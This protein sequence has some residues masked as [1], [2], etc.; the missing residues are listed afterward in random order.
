MVQSSLKTGDLTDLVALLQ[1]ANL[2]GWEIRRVRETSDQLYLNF[3]QMESLRRV[4]AETYAVQIY[5]LL[6][7]DGKTWLGESGWTAN[8][9]DDF[10]ADLTKARERALLALNPIFH[11]P[12]PDQHYQPLSL[13]DDFIKAQPRQVLWH[14]RHD[15][16]QAMANVLDIELAAA[17][18]Y[19]NY[20]KID[21]RNHTGL[22][23]SYEETELQTEFA[24]LAKTGGQEAESLG[25]RRAGFYQ[26][27]QIG[28]MV[29]RYSRY[30][31]E[32]A[33]A[34]MPPSGQCPVVFGEEALDTIFN[35]VCA[36]AGGQAAF[37]GWSTFKIGEPVIH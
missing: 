17:E 22:S 11:L 23:G 14:V 37:Q 3:D 6:E 8:P 27:L 32:N 35:H 25:W 20:R 24:L 16:N 33:L 30:A 10:A 31:L 2:Y 4:E 34:E 7:K 19:V 9:G 29:R 13:A 12:G 18:V 28:D 26:N 1:S 5:L 21:F 36:Q 15:L